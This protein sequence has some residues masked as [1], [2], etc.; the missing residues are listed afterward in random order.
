MG[1][2]PLDTVG[3]I[4]VRGPSRAVGKSNLIQEVSIVAERSHIEER[5]VGP[6]S[7]LT[8]APKESSVGPVSVNVALIMT[9][10]EGPVTKIFT[11]AMTIFS[12]PQ[13]LRV[14]Q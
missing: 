14:D 5:N 7:D 3:S 8:P 13:S 4:E 11:L 10:V 1:P 9:G 12:L 6:S 2:E